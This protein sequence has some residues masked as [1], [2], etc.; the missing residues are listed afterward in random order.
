MRNKTYEIVYVLKDNHKDSIEGFSLFVRRYKA[1]NIEQAKNK[2]QKSK[3]YEP[4]IDYAS[5]INTN[6]SNIRSIYQ[7]KGEKWIYIN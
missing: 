5:L 3:F 7:I 4:L 2:F 6:G 1:K